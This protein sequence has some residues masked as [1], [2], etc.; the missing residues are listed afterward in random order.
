[1]INFLHNA[2]QAMFKMIRAG[3]KYGAYALMT[4]PII[5]ICIGTILSI[6]AGCLTSCSFENLSVGEMIIGAFLVIITIIIATVFAFILWSIILSIIVKICEIIGTLIGTIT[7]LI[8]DFLRW[9]FQNIGILFRNIYGVLRRFFIRVYN[10]FDRDW[11]LTKLF[12]GVVYLYACCICLFCWIYGCFTQLEST[13]STLFTIL[14]TFPIGFYLFINLMVIA[15]RVIGNIFLLAGRIL[16]ISGRFMLSLCELFG[17]L[18]F[19]I[20]KALNDRLMY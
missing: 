18:L 17:R 8:D 5:F 3:I 7:L 10:Y 14:F 19:R 16:I 4:F 9:G 13:F 1:M 2:F 12:V 15:L 6:I 11:E 20:S